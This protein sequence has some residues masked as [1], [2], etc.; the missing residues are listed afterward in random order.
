MTH[1]N[2]RL[3]RNGNPIAWF[4]HAEQIETILK[5]DPNP[6]WTVQFCLPDNTFYEMQLAESGW[7]MFTPE[8]S[9]AFDTAINQPIGD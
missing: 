2:Y 1:S 8:A 9:K 5:S 7:L 4:T 6:G 3:L